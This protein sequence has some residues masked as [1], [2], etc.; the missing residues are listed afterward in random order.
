MY[1]QHLYKQQYSNFCKIQGTSTQAWGDKEQ[2]VD[3]TWQMIP[4]FGKIRF[5][6]VTFKEW[7]S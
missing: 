2:I 6:S 4:F 7:V 3:I 5:F 1:K